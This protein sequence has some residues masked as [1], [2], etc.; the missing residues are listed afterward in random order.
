MTR[1]I[2]QTSTNV[3]HT[4]YLNMFWWEMGGNMK[5][6]DHRQRKIIMLA[7]GCN[8]LCVNLILYKLNTE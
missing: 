8:G 6:N 3:W 1:L 7:A 5:L 4:F 2:T